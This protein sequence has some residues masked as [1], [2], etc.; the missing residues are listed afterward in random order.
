MKYT[1]I[2][3][4]CFKDISTENSLGKE[5]IVSL[6]QNKDMIIVLIMK[7]MSSSRVTVILHVN[8]STCPHYVAPRGL[9]LGT[10]W[11]KTLF[12]DNG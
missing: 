8:V 2:S 4:C 3:L 7:K 1:L 5:D 9:G 10:W 11:G 6:E 12:S